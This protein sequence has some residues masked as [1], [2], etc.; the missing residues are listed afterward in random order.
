MEKINKFLVSDWFTVIL[1][2]AAVGVVFSGQEIIGT[3][4]FVL[5]FGRN[6]VKIL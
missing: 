6:C 1:L 4:V 2:V 5:I 3:I